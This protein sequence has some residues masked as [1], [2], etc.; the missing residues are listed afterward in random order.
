M[1]TH[2]RYKGLIRHHGLCTEPGRVS[3]CTLTIL[4]GKGSGVVLFCSILSAFEA[5]SLFLKSV[6]LNPWLSQAAVAE[7]CPLL[8]KEGFLFSKN[9]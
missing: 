1:T 7:G 2:I 6:L 9:L 4:R 8:S 5:Q 3:H